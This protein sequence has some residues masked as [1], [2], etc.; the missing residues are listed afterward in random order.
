MFW[1]TGR[2]QS[3]SEIC[4]RHRCAAMPARCKRVSFRAN[5]QRLTGTAKKAKS[6]I[7]GYLSVPTQMGVP[8]PGEHWGA[9]RIRGKGI[10]E[11]AAVY[12]ILRNETYIGRFYA[13]KYIR[14]KKLRTMRPKE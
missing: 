9:T 13:F 2:T 5:R 14:T 3:S 11:R 8:T 12:N 6:M 7:R 4:A 10:W 1:L